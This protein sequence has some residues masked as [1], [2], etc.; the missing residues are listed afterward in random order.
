MEQRIGSALDVTGII[1]HG[2][3]ARGV[4]GAG[5]ALAIKNR[6]PHVYA[7]YRTQYE[8]TGLSL[9]TVLYVPAEPKVFI[10]NAITQDSTGTGLQVS[11]PAIRECFHNI[12]EVAREL[13]L[14]VH[15]PKI[16]AG[17][18][19]GDW[20]VISKIIDRELRGCEHYNWVLALDA[21]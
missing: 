18:G 4:M 8:E 11:Y 10:A 5:I 9:G 2:C 19:G 16:G 12:G 13:S 20:E 21:A 1:V 7:A 6:W 15:Y 17:L 3:N 14:P